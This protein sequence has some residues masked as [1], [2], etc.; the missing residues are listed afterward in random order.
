[1]NFKFS[2]NNSVLATFIFFRTFI[3]HFDQQ[4]E[5]IITESESIKIISLPNWKNVV[6]ILYTFFR[7]CSS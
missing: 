5:K 3:L 4:M 6:G 2:S 7:N 1:M